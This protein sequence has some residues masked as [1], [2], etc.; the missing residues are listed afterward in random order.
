MSKW[1]Y[2]TIMML[3]AGAGIILLLTEKKQAD[4]NRKESDRILQEFRTL[5]SSLKVSNH[6][7]DSL[8]KTLLDSLSKK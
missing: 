4:E 3:L 7:I 6:Q 5:D 8:N 1:I 2:I